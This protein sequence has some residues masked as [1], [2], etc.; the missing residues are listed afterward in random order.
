M[1]GR[2]SAAEDIIEKIATTAKENAKCRKLLTQ[3]I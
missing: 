3:N 2:M 1:E